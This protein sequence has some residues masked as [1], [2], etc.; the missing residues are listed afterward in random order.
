MSRRATASRGGPIG[1]LP[2]AIAVLAG[3][4]G[5]ACADPAPQDLPA[6]IYRLEPA[7]SQLIANL[8]FLGVSHYPVTFSRMTG[9]V[10]MRRQTHTAPRVTIRVDPHSI[11]SSHSVVARTMLSMMEPQRF[12]LLGFTARAQ[13]ESDGRMWLLGDLTLHGVTR[14]VRLALVVEQAARGTDSPTGFAVQGRTRIR[15]S[16]FGM[17]QMR[18]L[19][20]DQVDLT[21][22]AEFTRSPASDAPIQDSARARDLE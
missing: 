15:R 10:E 16:D 4:A 18:A 19:V 6:G 11:S 8:R 12:P 17:P 20:G 1:W 2:L 5:A 21:F 7:R 3:A 22:Q 13:G 9:R 14:P